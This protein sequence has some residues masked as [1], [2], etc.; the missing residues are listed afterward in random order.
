MN[1]DGVNFDPEQ[2]STSGQSALSESQYSSSG[3]SLGGISETS[4]KSRR[5]GSKKSSR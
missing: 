1:K 2:M 3:Q 5:K 4:K